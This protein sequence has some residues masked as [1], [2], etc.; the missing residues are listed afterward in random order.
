MADSI[1]YKS[2]N[3]GI[4]T[5]YNQLP[6]TIQSGTQKEFNDAYNKWLVKKGLEPSGYNK[7]KSFK[8]GNQKNGK[9]SI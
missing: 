1:Q 5:D 8:F 6:Q 3:V 4:G 7:K 2:S 9:E